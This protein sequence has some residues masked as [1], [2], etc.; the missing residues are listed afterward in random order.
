M[1]F[2]A[3]I[4]VSVCIS[5]S[6]EGIFH[7]TLDTSQIAQ[8]PTTNAGVWVPRILRKKFKITQPITNN[9]K[10]SKQ[11]KCSTRKQG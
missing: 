5:V 8:T 11:K 7:T 9:M 1:Q 10:G 6:L 3:Q 2:E 4:C